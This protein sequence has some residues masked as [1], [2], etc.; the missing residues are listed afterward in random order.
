MTASYAKLN[1]NCKS[2]I[3]FI[4]TTG[5]RKFVTP[6]AIPAHLDAE[7]YIDVI[8]PAGFKGVDFENICLILEIKGP[9]GAKFM[10][11]PR[12][13]SG[14]H[15]GIPTASG[16]DWDETSHSP[17]PKVRLR[18]PHDA[19]SSGGINGL[20]FWL[21]L[22]GLP[23]PTTTTTTPPL[24]S[25]TASATADRVSVSNTASCAIQIK[26]L[27]VGEQLTGFLGRD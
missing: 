2:D 24:V 18:N 25:F 27:G 20:S 17:A 3:L 16:S 22:T 12:M 1:A 23:T 7:M 10:P 19:L 13:G 11:N 14:V 4:G 6:P 9:S 21:G 15:W 26:D 8:V 5:I